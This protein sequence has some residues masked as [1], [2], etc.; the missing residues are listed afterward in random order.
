M[1]FELFVSGYSH[2]EIAEATGTSTRTVRRIADSA[3]AERR[4]AAPDHYVRVQVAR[5]SEALKLAGYRIGRAT[6]AAWRPSQTDRRWNAT[7]PSTGGLDGRARRNSRRRP[8][9]LP[10]KQEARP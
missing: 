10:K 5:L 7:T 2:H 1:V 8:W 6:C 3:V 4:L 9:F